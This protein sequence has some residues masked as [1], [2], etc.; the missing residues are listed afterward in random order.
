MSVSTGYKRGPEVEVLGQSVFQNTKDDEKQAASIEDLAFLNLMDK[1]VHKDKDNS[2]LAPLPFKPL[3]QRLPCNKDQARQRLASLRNS[4]EKNPKK[5]Q[6]F[7]E[8]VQKMIDNGHAEP[9]PFL[10]T[11]RE[12]WY[13]PMFGVHI[14]QK[15][16]QIRVVF[17]SSAEFKGTSLN[18]VLLS[19]PDL[20]YSLVGVLMRFRKEP[21]AFMA[22]IQQLFYCFFVEQTLGL[23]SFMWFKDNDM[24]KMS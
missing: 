8:F 22:D 20:N 24:S 5:R 4:L 6:Q 13:L 11:N 9:A 19:G 7:L 2:W 17:D 12:H 23:P 10:D 3:R 14:P 21:T 16:D 15:P 1:E 18:K